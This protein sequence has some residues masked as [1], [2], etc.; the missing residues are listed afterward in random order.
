MIQH[1]IH[2]NLS[3]DQS[4]QFF[5]L[6]QVLLLYVSLSIV[7]IGRGLLKFWQSKNPERR[8][9]R[10]NSYFLLMNLKDDIVLSAAGTPAHS[11]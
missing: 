1:P 7:A 2:D 5:L 3:F 6:D 8:R 9:I 10:K 4:Q 11:N